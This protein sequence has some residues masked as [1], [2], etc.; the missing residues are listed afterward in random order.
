MLRGVLVADE[1]QPGVQQPLGV[2]PVGVVVAAAQDLHAAVVLRCGQRDVRGLVDHVRTLGLPREVGGVEFPLAGQRCALVLGAAED[3]LLIRDPVEVP[4]LDGH[5][6]LARDL[7]GASGHPVGVGEPGELVVVGVAHDVAGAVLEPHQV[8]RRLLP[9]AGAGA[10][11]AEHHPMGVGGGGD[12]PGQVADRVIGDLR[13]V[14]A[15]LQRQVAAGQ[16]GAQHVAGNAGECGQQR[17]TLVGQAEPV[18]EHAGSEPDGDGEGRRGE[19]VGLAGVGADGVRT[20]GLDGA[21]RLAL[22]ELRD[23]GAP[24]GQQH[25]QILPGGA[26]GQVERHVDAVPLRRRP[27]AGLMG[28]VVEGDAAGQVDGVGARGRR[29]R[30]RGASHHAGGHPRTH[31]GTGGRRGCSAGDQ[32]APGQSGGRSGGRARRIGGRFLSHLLLRSAPRRLV[33]SAGP[34]WPWRPSRRSSAS[35]AAGPARPG[36]APGDACRGWPRSRAGSHRA[37][38]CPAARSARHQRYRTG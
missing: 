7:V 2:E 33:A 22:R 26:G 28:L 18:V 5:R 30:L 13:V 37:T 16:L 32:P 15:G 20:L 27:D 21:D 29:R 12:H 10:P 36:S 35:A 4:G 8:P 6:D 14:G 17:R 9:G 34:I 1:Q 31:G 25:L 38:P 24:P 3:L 23:R 19:P 11:E